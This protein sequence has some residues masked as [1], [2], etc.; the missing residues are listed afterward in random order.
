MTSPYTGKQFTR[1][2]ALRLE[3]AHD[4]ILGLKKFVT[5]R[6]I[7]YEEM[8]QL[9]INKGYG[10]NVDPFHVETKTNDAGADIE[11]FKIEVSYGDSWNTRYVPVAFVFS[12]GE[13]EKKYREAQEML[14]SFSPVK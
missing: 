3:N 4:E 6:S 1:K 11:V 7:A 2:D 10:R 8:L 13:F 12:D 14:A 5:E 9:D